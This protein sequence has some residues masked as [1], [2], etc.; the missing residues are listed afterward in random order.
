MRRRSAGTAMP[1]LASVRTSPSRRTTP[2]SGS[3]SPEMTL[4]RVLLPL[5]ERPKSAMIPGVG[6]VKVAS[7]RNP[8]SSLT[9]ETSSTSAAQIT[10]HAAD[11]QLRDQQADQAER[12]GED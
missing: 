9:T 10:A 11:Q 8:P 12:E 3:S 2:A 4:V 1:R 7:R 5:P 6:A